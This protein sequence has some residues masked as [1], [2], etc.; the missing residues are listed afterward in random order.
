[1]ALTDPAADLRAAIEAKLLATP[2]L[3][4]LIEKRIFDRVPA[5]PDYPLVTIGNIQVLP[6]SADGVDAA[7]S[8][9]TVHVWD[10]YKRADKA[11]PVG[12]LVISALHEE[13]LQTDG[14][15]T[16]SILLESANYLRDPDGVTNHGILTFS[17]LTDANT[18]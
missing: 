1:M 7:E 11:K 18:D 9:V 2:A 4:A 8:I 3:F 12:A 17:I 13:E 14:V 6:E 15:G 16:Q 10:Q 5:K